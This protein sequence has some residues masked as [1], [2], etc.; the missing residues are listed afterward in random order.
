MST[1]VTLLGSLVTI[2]RVGLDGI[3][4]LWVVAVPATFFIIGLAVSFLFGLMK[5]GSRRRGR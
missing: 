5:R 2:F 4:G 1:I 3:A